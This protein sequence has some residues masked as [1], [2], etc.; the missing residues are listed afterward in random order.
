MSGQVDEARSNTKS[1][2]LIY[3]NKL[4]VEDIGLYLK[5]KG[6]PNDKHGGGAVP[7]L[8]RIF[9]G[10]CRVTVECVPLPV[11]DPHVLIAT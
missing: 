4:K 3:C 6:I 1:K 2:I 5:E 11:S 7:S 9:E 8:G 10:G